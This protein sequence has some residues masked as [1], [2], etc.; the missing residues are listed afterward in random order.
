L[1]SLRVLFVAILA[2][3]WPLAL[4]AAAPG[5]LDPSFG[6]GGR[7]LTSV[8][9]G[10]K[11][12]VTVVVQ[13]DGRIV[14]VGN[15]MGPLIAIAVARY[16]RDGSLDTT[17]GGTGE[18]TTTP[19]GAS[20]AY[21]TSAAIQQ[22][23][24]V[25]AVGPSELGGC[26]V[27]RYN[28]DGSL[29]TTFG[30]TGVV[31]VP[32][33][34]GARAVAIQSDGKIVVAGLSGADFAFELVLAR[35]NPDGLP[36]P[37]FNGTGASATIPLAYGMQANAAV[38][39]LAIG[40]DGKIVSAA[41]GKESDIATTAGT[42]FVFRHNGDGTPDTTFN[43]TGKLSTSANRGVRQLMMPWFPYAGGVA[44]QGDGKILIADHA[45]N[46]S[47]KFEFVLH[48]FGVD[49]SPDTTFN[50][51]GSVSTLMGQSG[52]AWAVAVQPNGRIVVAGDTV[53]GSTYQFAAARYL[54]DG[55]L[56]T[57][58]DTDGR[59]EVGFE[60]SQAEARSVALMATGEIVLAGEASIGTPPNSLGHF[61]LMRLVGDDTGAP[62]T[63]VTSAPP[64]LSGTSAMVY[65]TGTDT[66]ASGVVAYECSL[67]GAAFTSCMSPAIFYGL[68]DGSHAFSVRARDAAGNVDP[69]PATYTWVS[70]A[71]A[72]V[73]RLG[74]ISTRGQV[75]TGDNVTIGGFIIGGSA[76]KTVLI[77]ARGPSMIPAGVVNA[78]ADPQMTLVD[79]A[80]AAVIATNDN[81]GDAPNA[82]AISATGLAPTEA[83]ESAILVTLNPGAYTAVVSGVGGTTGVG[84]VEVFEIDRPEA[85][86]TNISTRGQVLTG[87][88]VMIGGFIVQGSGPQTVLVRVRG[89][90][91]VPAGVADAL[92]DPQVTL[93]NQATGVIIATNDNWGSAANASEI[94]ATGL[95]PTNA[96]E[97]AI[98]VTLNP[99]AYTAV[100]SG[101]GGL[102]GVGIVEVF[103]Q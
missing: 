16:N 95:A 71:F 83:F 91:M 29:D 55:S 52:R 100:V 89:P 30:G 60:A 54:P 92:A 69:S 40:A 20:V 48:R 66:G 6:T 67:D 81:W 2:L 8:T 5:D 31:V 18:V 26:T 61:A 4:Q 84:I 10:S 21:A 98:L 3:G 7:V 41:Y 74:N 25:V 35:V 12:V 51:T 34:V 57:S 19:A 11:G 45:L 103:A 94:A 93:V 88:D 58:F 56:D 23:G 101:V 13:S 33:C 37:S 65:F 75:Q 9:P 77:R 28:G 99:G 86:L 73:P 78:M 70:S 42:T 32:L 59:I 46:A 102:T 50:G 24:K 63:A 43:G 38:I 36:D 80:T 90:S 64:S 72:A 97:S 15:T 96:F 44:L 17:F 39:G 14:A 22:D 53:N 49:G 85:P 79:Q 47:G 62:D 68:A 27:V 76:P 82:G 87:D 1:T